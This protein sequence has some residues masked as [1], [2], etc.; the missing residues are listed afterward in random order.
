MPPAEIGTAQQENPVSNV[1]VVV[2]SDGEQDSIHGIY[3]DQVLAWQTVQE[4]RSAQAIAEEQAWNE[5]PCE[6]GN[7]AC[8]YHMSAFSYRWRVDEE[9][10]ITAKS[11]VSCQ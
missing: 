4:L 2:C 10:L 3:Q 8:D 6:C 5:H 11:L 1:Y 7:R 9:E